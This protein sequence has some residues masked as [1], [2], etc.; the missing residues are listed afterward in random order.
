MWKAGNQDRSIAFSTLSCFPHF[1]CF[2]PAPESK[3]L[4]FIGSTLAAPVSPA[5]AALRPL[6]FADFTGQLKT[7]ERLQV[8][9]G[10]AKSAARPSTT[11]CSPARPGS[12][13]PRSPSSSA[14]SSAAMCASPPAP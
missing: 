7:V 3:G 11:S 2:M 8:M 12:A 13:R 9:V 1:T 4:G 10:A 5:E 6:S 14:M